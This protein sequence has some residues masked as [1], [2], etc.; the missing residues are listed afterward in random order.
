M[1]SIRSSISNITGLHENKAG[2]VGLGVRSPVTC[3][4]R[5]VMF[6]SMFELRMC[7]VHKEQT[8]TL[9]VFAPVALMDG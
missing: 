2:V 1:G 9:R 8:E 7:T 3:P 5:R 6:R 4:N